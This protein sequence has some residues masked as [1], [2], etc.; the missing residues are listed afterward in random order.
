MV[1]CRTAYDRSTRKRRAPVSL[2]DAAQVSATYREAARIEPLAVGASA[3]RYVA[4]GSVT[5]GQYGLF[6]WDPNPGGGPGPHYHRTFSEAFYVLAGRISLYDGR[7]WIMAESGDFLYVPAYGIHAFRGEEGGPSSMLILF[8]PGEPRE[9]Y[10]TE[11]AERIA[12]GA[13]SSAE[14]TQAFLARH[15]QYMVDPTD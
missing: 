14:E 12:S 7:R 15:D 9:R 2:P 3:V 13:R 10:F 11:L 1:D 4:P 5:G 6:R 8:A